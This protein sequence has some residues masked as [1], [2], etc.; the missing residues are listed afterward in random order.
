[1]IWLPSSTKHYLRLLVAAGATVG[2]YACLNTQKAV[3]QT[4]VSASPPAVTPA[5]PKRVLVF[6]KTKGWKHT[7]IPFGI[8][9]IQKLGAENNFRV[10]TTKNADYFNDD[11][12]RNYQ[13]VVFLSTTGNVLNPVQ[14]AAFERYIQAGGGYMGIHAAA[15]TEYDWPWYNKLVGAYFSSHPSNSNVRKATVDVTDKNHLS[16]AHLPDHWERTDEW[17]NYRSFYTDLNVLANLDEN[18]YDG[19][20]NGANHPIAWYHEFDGGRAFYTGGGHEDAS[21]SEPLF[22]KHLLGGLN[23]VMGNGKPLDYSKSYAVVMP[24]ENRFVKTVLVNDLNEPMELA[25][26]DDGRVFFTERSGNLSVYNP[27][28]NEHKI[29]HKFSVSTKQ[30]FGVQGVTV[31]PNFATNHYLYLYYSPMA[32]KDPVYHLS[33]FV[34]K[35]DNTIDLASEKVVLK[36]PHEFEASAHH[37]GSFAW[38]KEGNLYLSTGDNTNPFPSNGYAPIDERPDHLTLDAQRSAANTNDLRGKV[39]RIRPQPDGTYT[40]PDGN[41]FPK[42]M[43]QTRPEIYTMGLRNPYR[44]AVNPKSSV[45]YW[46]EIGPDAGKDSTIGPR[47]YDEFNQ[48]KKPGNFGWPLFIGNSQPYPDLDFATNV[49]GPRFDSNAPV[50]SSP[51]NTGMKTLPPANPAMIWY[52]YAA[53]KEFPEVGQ[54][55]RSAMAGA[56][57]T[58][59]QNSGSKNKFPAY[60]DGMLFIFDW[61][62]NWVMAVRVDQNDNYIRN[63][64]FM[65]TNGDFRRPIDLAFNKDGVMYM[66]EYGSVYGADNDDARLVKIEYN[67]GNR[68]PVARATVVDSLATAQASA[69]SFLTSD[70]RNSPATREA[71]GQAPLRVKFSGRGTDL[72]QDDVLNY[73]WLFD[74]KTVGS[75]Q[76]N[77]TYTYTQPGV[78]NAI[79]KVSDQ[80]GLVAMDTVVVKVGNAKPEVAITTPGNKSFFWAG[81]PFTYS[82]KVSD[83]EDQKIDPKRIKVYYAYSAQPGNAPTAAP[84]Q[85]HQDLAAIGNGSLGKTLIAGSDCKACH[86]I[87]KPSVGPTFLAVASRYKGQPGVVE[88]LAKKI[89]EGG[90]G[91]W[92]KDHLMS[93]H[94]QIPAQDAQEMVKYIFSL[95]DEQKQKTVPLQGTLALTDHKADEPRGQYTLV[96]AYTDNGGQ[97]VGPITSTDVVSLRPAKVRTLDADAYVGFPRWGNRLSAGGHKAYVL[98][99]GIDMTGI[100]SLTYDY[101][102]LDKD[103]EI[104]LRLDSYAGPVVNRTP[105]KATGDWKNAGQVTAQLDKPITGKHDVYVVVVKRDKPSNNIIQLNSIEFNE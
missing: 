38:D 13:A 43:A 89:I 79:L 99:K 60:Y 59:D 103:G 44:I 39:L 32:D 78:Y 11:S 58:H 12:L 67:T 29:L 74:G 42:G 101:S 93:A 46:G 7:S 17:Y 80:T 102:S 105:Y 19:G 88:R 35:D 50:N 54:G 26:A 72:D 25:I 21:F 2:L 40:I 53:S 24:E 31:D 87:D 48:A 77:A 98:L 33:R 84:Q 66:L 73:Q 82:V 1:M 76:P 56:F 4:T 22:V 52:P 5:T 3:K 30:G 81:K 55:G 27:R 14:Q 96:A 104:E 83:K 70:N 92:S 18:T 36:I 69:R 62:R 45:L 64:P 6:S 86:T 61:M 28:T 16:T 75:T 57:Y 49:A 20:T 47:G 41:L 10:D 91:N 37:G 8:A 94:P 90:G 34:I 51:N 100:K 23:Y 97:V 15:D 71:V 65:A 63:E 9:A 68:A 85:G 95:T